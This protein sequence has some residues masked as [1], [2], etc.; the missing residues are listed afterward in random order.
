ME[1]SGQWSLNSDTRLRSGVGN[2]QNVGDKKQGKTT[3]SEHCVF[4]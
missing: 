2:M 3:M 4:S 1:S